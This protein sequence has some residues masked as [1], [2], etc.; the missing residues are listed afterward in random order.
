MY[1]LLVYCY[2]KKT[3]YKAVNEL[4]DIVIDNSLTNPI[5]NNA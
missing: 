1:T 2:I 4:I 3:I 5:F